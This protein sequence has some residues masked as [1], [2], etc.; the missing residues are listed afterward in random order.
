M[1]ITLQYLESM[2]NWNY[3][4]KEVTGEDILEKTFFTFHASNV[5]LQQQCREKGFKK[6]SEL[7]S[8]LLMDVLNNELLMK[9][10]EFCPTGSTP[11]LEVNVTTHNSYNYGQ[12]REWGHRHNCG[13]GRGR[14]N[15]WVYYHGGHLKYSS[16]YLKWKNKEEKNENEKSGQIS[17][18]V[19]NPCYCWSLPRIAQK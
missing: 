6:Y 12:T 17:K 19:D 8:C 10:N 9:N 7:I 5:L 1:S 15:N 3:V 14:W 18:H 11:F 2:L 16:P 4:E 13:R